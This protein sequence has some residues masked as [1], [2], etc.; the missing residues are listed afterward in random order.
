MKAVTN[1]KTSTAYHEAGHAVM[2]IY[3]HRHI[4]KV[5]SLGL[6]SDGTL[7][8]WG[9]LG[10]VPTCDSG[11]IAIAAGGDHCLALEGAKFIFEGFFSPIDANSIN[12]ANA[13]QT[14]PVKWKIT[15]KDGTPISDPASFVSLKSYVV[16]CTTFEGDPTNTIDEPEAGSS[17][18]QYLGDGWW[19]YNWKTAKA[20]QGQCRTMKLT[21]DDGTVHTA[22]FSFK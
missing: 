13:G 3:Y 19:Q 11:F 10:D 12:K 9:G 2:N 17:G 16:N 21:L 6:K 14:I 5:S 1:P 4:G 18:L 8:A 20:Y 15:S 7:V 22:N